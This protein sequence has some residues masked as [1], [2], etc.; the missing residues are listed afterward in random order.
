[1][2]IAAA[3]N[4][5]ID[6]APTGRIF[7]YEIFP[8]Y[9]KAPAAVVRAVSRCIENRGL[10]RIAKGRFYK[11]RKGALGDVPIGD[12]ERLRDALYRKGRR[13]G[14]ITGPAL[15]NRLGLTT[16]MPKSISV[17]VNGATQIKDLGTMRIKLQ[18]RRAPI[19]D[20]T[21][22]LLET[23]DVLRD[24]RKLPGTDLQRVIQA[25]AKRL[26]EFTSAERKKLQ[27]M[28][29]DYYRPGTRAL[30]GMLLTHCGNEVLPA[31]KASL[32]P[33]T[34]FDLGIDFKVWPESQSWSIR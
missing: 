7:G 30:L 11:P 10:K 17:A 9:R 16:Q 5:A 21:V 32:N 1:M 22:P 13:I 3:V 12:D 27:R 18:T 2:S 8:Q 33:T 24:A 15:Y 29:L 34:R 23:L 14:Y 31:L 4:Q 6:R 26:T 25:I 19:S 20:S 28:A